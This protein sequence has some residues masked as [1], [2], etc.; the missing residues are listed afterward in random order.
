MTSSGIADCVDLVPHILDNY[1]AS[2]QQHN[3]H[4]LVCL[5]VSL[6]VSAYLSDFNIPL[7]SLDQT[8]RS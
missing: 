7:T 2:V 8:H 6:S 4:L 1:N 5:F 3:C